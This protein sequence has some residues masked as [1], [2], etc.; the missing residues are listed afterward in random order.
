VIVIG[1]KHAEIRNAAKA[2][3]HNALRAEVDGGVYT[4]KR[5][6]F[7]EQF[8]RQVRVFLDYTRPERADLGGV[9]DDWMTRLRI[10]CFGRD[11]GTDAGADVADDLAAR[12]YAIL[13]ADADLLALVMDLVPLGLA[14]DDDEAEEGVGV[15]QVLFDAK[16]RT[17]AVS[18]SA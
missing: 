5:R 3:L 8:R 7:A 1:S 4:G 13:A 9:P 12:C 10:E 14:W 15:T 16:H 2:A 17:P 18:I 6:V 11:D